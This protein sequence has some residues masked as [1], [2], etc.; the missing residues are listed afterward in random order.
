MFRRL[1]AEELTASLRPGEP[2]ALKVKA[3]GTIID[4]HYRVIVLWERGVAVDIP[5]RG[6]LCHEPRSGHLR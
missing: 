4:G 2:G 3:D 5:C 6:S 1:S